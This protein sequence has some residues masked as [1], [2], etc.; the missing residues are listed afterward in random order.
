MAYDARQQLLALGT[1]SGGVKLYPWIL[2]TLEEF[3]SSDGYVQCNNAMFGVLCHGVTVRIELK[4]FED[5]FVAG[6]TS[7]LYNEA[8]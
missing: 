8:S 6:I 1:K 4:V 5:Y 3:W 7:V 2:N